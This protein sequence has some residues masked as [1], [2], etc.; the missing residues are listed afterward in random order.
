LST[1][2]CRGSFNEVHLQQAIVRL[3]LRYTI[4]VFLSTGIKETIQWIRRTAKTLV[5]DPAV[6]KEG[7]ATTASAAAIV[8]TE[9]IHVKKAENNSPER[10][11]LTFLLSIP[12]MGK[13]TATAV[14]EAVSHSL[15]GLQALSVEDLSAVKVGK[16]RLGVALATAIHTAVHS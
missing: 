11:F 16:R 15:T 13:A 6:F 1:A 7:L 14:A 3:Q 5:A 9:A 8:Y 4:P 10:L 12:G 2:W